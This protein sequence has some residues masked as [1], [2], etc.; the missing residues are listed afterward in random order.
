MKSAT[1][2][3]AGRPAVTA[4]RL[5]VALA[6]TA[7]SSTGGFVNDPD[8]E[9]VSDAAPRDGDGIAADAR[10]AEAGPPATD[11]VAPAA[12]IGPPTPLERRAL[13]L[14]IERRTLVSRTFGAAAPGVPVGPTTVLHSNMP[15][16]AGEA[17]T[18]VEHAPGHWLGAVRRLPDASL[19][20]DVAE[21]CLGGAIVTLHVTPERTRSLGR[22][23]SSTCAW[24]DTDTDWLSPDGRWYRGDRVDDHPEY[25][26][27][28]EFIRLDSPN[29]RVPFAGC[30]ERREEEARFVAWDGEGSVLT[31]LED[32]CLMRTELDSGEVHE[33]ALPDPGCRVV[34]GEGDRALRVGAR[35]LLDCESGVH[36]LLPDGTAEMLAEE[37]R[38]EGGRL[39]TLPKVE[40]GGASL[41][42]SRAG[43]RSLFHL[44]PEGETWFA[45]LT[46]DWHG[47]RLVADSRTGQT[48]VV[49]YKSDPGDAAHAMVRLFAVEADGLRETLSARLPAGNIDSLVVGDARVGPL[50][51]VV[52]HDSHPRDRTLHVVN[53]DGR[54]AEH[55]AT[56]VDACSVLP[57]HGER[58]LAF[59]HCLD[60]TAIDVRDA[61]T[62]TWPLGR[63]LTALTSAGH[64]EAFGFDGESEVAVVDA[65]GGLERGR[66]APG[67]SRRV[68]TA[69]GITAVLRAAPSLGAP[70]SA[71]DVVDL[72]RPGAAEAFATFPTEGEVLGFVGG[73][74]VTL[75]D[76]VLSA[77]SAE[78]VAPQTF[79]LPGVVPANIRLSEAAAGV[80]FA[81]DD[82]GT[83]SR[84]ALSTGD[85]RVV[86][87][88]LPR[89]PMGRFHHDA[90]LELVVVRFETE[91]AS[92]FALDADA[93]APALAPTAAL[94][95]A[96]VDFAPGDDGKGPLGW[97]TE[98]V[99]RLCA[100]DCAPRR[101]SE[102]F[103]SAYRVTTDGTHLFSDRG[104]S[105]A[106]A[107]PGVPVPAKCDDGRP[108][109][110]ISDEVPIDLRASADGARVLLGDAFVVR[111]AD[112]RATRLEASA[113]P[114]TTFSARID[115]AH[116]PG[117]VAA[118]TEFHPGPP[119]PRTEPYLSFLFYDAALRP[120][121]TR[122]VELVGLHSWDSPVRV[123]SLNADREL[124]VI[125]ARDRR[126]TP[127]SDFVALDA[128]PAGGVT[129]NHTVVGT[130][131][132]VW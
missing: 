116:V 131:R 18:Y 74:V 53:G 115:A 84:I 33:V 55:L 36:A 69:D 122:E 6:A 13:Q 44:T 79:A 29:T 7:C 41:V 104:L 32:Y 127:L 4:L 38:L 120:V 78:S 124:G 52:E 110:P 129:A 118:V 106:L 31:G 87:R 121:G 43:E 26:R 100:G 10:S 82:E 85:V 128:R 34:V 27:E 63:V 66:I 14:L 12:D 81:L 45:P 99:F 108:C 126:S 23:E 103:G 30:P 125:H 67:V 75:H 105:V 89:A 94:A 20:L 59:W 19:V 9:D 35:L 109:E 24:V 111:P 11:A 70:G 65:T 58:E 21:Q 54:P 88:N 28:P 113:P 86:A 101:L 92:V 112:G 62:R 130:L 1:S 95:G 49:T 68:G 76:G 73:Q 22:G 37:W 16:S 61:V 90:G 5:G 42:V 60:T 47:L 123:L 57:W 114:G 102:A 3:L 117:G 80:A 17:R 71:P 50:F 48:A 77:R 93:G 40:P 83:L 119:D 25:R 98:A 46:A 56:T 107:V 132:D 8:P 72:L 96:G 2:K 91:P 97:D 39:D 51:V 64:M 15:L